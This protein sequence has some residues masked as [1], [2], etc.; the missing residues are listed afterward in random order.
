[1]FEESQGDD[2]EAAGWKLDHQLQV[3]KNEMP[4][5]GVIK[6][7]NCKKGACTW[8]EVEMVMMLLSCHTSNIKCTGSEHAL[9]MG[10]QI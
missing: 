8:P 5:L 9:L 1:M 4:A 10:E 2:N 3:P 6:V 7:T